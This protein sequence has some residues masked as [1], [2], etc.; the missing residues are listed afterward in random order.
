MEATG[1]LNTLER[2]RADGVDK[3]PTNTNHLRLYSHNLCPF[4]ARAR[5]ALA[6]NGI[7]F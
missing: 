5:Y 2:I 6:A 1:A 4:A 7:Q 3:P